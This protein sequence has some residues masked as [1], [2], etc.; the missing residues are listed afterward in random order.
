[1]VIKKLFALVLVLAML[2]GLGAVGA[3]AEWAEATPEQTE[4]AWGYYAALCGLMQGDYTVV[5]TGGGMDLFYK[6]MTASLIRPLVTTGRLRPLLQ[7]DYT[8]TTPDLDYF[9]VY[10]DWGCKFLYGKREITRPIGLLPVNVKPGV[11][12]DGNMLRLG[13]YVFT[14]GML[15]QYTYTDYR[16]GELTKNIVWITAGVDDTS[17]FDIFGSCRTRPGWF[18]YPIILLRALTVFFPFSLIYVFS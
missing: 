13:N 2:C 5:Y 6:G 3:S 9:V 14:D 4:E 12:A 7:N 16:F 8:I 15:T 10:P 17:L 11:H 1:M 18:E